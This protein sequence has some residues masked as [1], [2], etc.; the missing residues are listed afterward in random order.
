MQKKAKVFVPP[1]LT[2]Q[3]ARKG[4]GTTPAP[5]VSPGAVLSAVEELCPDV[6]EDCSEILEMPQ[7]LCNLLEPGVIP[8]LEESHPT[9]YTI[10]IYRGEAVARRVRPS[11]MPRCA[12]GEVLIYGSELFLS[13]PDV[14]GSQ[15]EKDFKEGGYTH[16]LVLLAGYP[17]G[18]PRPR[19]LYAPM[20]YRTLVRNIAGANPSFSL[21][22][23]H[24]KGWKKA[25]LLQQLQRIHREATAS[26]NSNYESVAAPSSD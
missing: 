15:Q 8:I 1:H 2:S 24:L 14:K 18:Y 17:E 12:S 7:A 22:P 3:F 26:V 25:E 20:A 4:G 9:D 13:D 23:E 10:E 21:E 5:G 11:E 19:P 16:A 6:E